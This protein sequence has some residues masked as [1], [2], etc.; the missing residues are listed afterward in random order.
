MKESQGNSQND[1]G[2]A[3]FEGDQNLSS[4]QES[5]PNSTD[6]GNQMDDTWDAFQGESPA[7]GQNNLSSNITDPFDV[8]SEMFFLHLIPQPSI[9]FKSFSKICSH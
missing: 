1:A 3:A 4:K 9:S 7:T 5:T 6:F 2:W 8:K